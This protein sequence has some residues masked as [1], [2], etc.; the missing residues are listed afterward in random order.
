MS[1]VGMS[2]GGVGEAEDGVAMDS[3][4]ASGLAD[5]VA[6]G[7][8]VQDRDGGGFGEMAA[9]Q[10]GPLA[11]REAGAAGVAVELPEL[12]V[13]ADSAADGEVADVSL[14]VERTFG[15]LAAEMSEVVHGRIGPGER[16]DAIKGW[17]SK[18]SLIL[19][20]IP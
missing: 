19:R 11:F 2:S 5:A 16:R 8:V 3:E 10:R 9:V 17:E 13:L 20:R 4:E 15:L 6:F 18:A 14:T 7:Q 1:V 12:L